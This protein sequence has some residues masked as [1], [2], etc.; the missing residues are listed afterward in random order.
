MQ[1]KYKC[2]PHKMEEIFNRYFFID[3]FLV[4]TS[5]PFLYSSPT[6]R[7]RYHSSSKP[8]RRKSFQ[9]SSPRS[10][11]PHYL[12][13]RSFFYC[14]FVIIFIIYAC[15]V[16]EGLSVFMS[17][18]QL[19]IICCSWESEKEKKDFL[20][21]CVSRKKEDEEEEEEEKKSRDRQFSLSWKSGSSDK[22]S[23]KEK[24]KQIGILI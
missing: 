17:S 11:I 4:V 13:V 20:V 14:L 19:T 23:E 24:Q 2:A 22:S 7:F 10:W 18:L 15:C 16:F 3:Y 12:F 6:F 5:T 21:N 1:I 8:F 9:H